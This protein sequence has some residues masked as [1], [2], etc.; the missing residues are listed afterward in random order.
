V[1]LAPHALCWTDQ[2]LAGI[3]AGPTFA[4]CSTCKHGREPRGEVNRAVL[5]Q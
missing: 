3:G 4:P 1:I 5:V 2:W